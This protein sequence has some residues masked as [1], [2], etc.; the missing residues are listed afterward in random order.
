MLKKLILYLLCFSMVSFLA[1]EVKTQSINYLFGYPGDN[2]ATT[3]TQVSEGESSNTL[4]YII[5]AVGVGTLLYFELTSD[6][7]SDSL[8]TANE[9][10]AVMLNVNF[11]VG[12][13]FNSDLSIGFSLQF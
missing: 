8:G 13:T 4:F 1:Q 11:G 7:V 2:T 10:D 9:Q 5:V 12:H 3:S 6:N